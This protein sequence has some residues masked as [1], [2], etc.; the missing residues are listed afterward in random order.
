MNGLRGPTSVSSRGR[1][2]PVR[3]YEDYQTPIWVIDLLLDHWRPME[4]SRRVTLVEPCAGEGR[5]LQRFGK[6]Y[7]YLDTTG[8]EIQPK[9]IPLLDPLVDCLEIGD[10]RQSTGRWDVGV[11][12]PP[13]SLIYECAQWGLECCR[14]FAMLARVGFMETEKR[15]DLVRKT[16]PDLYLLPNRPSFVGKSFDSTQYAWWTWPGKGRYTMLPYLSKE[17]RK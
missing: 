1:G 9:Y 6:R 3:G 14:H 12:N 11:T 7:K 5:I 16:T 4:Y 10:F 2:S 13:F 17:Q 8:I 15:S